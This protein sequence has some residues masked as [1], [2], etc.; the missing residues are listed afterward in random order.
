[1]DGMSGQASHGSK[2][3]VQPE[4]GVCKRRVHVQVGSD[5]CIALPEEWMRDLGQQDGDELAFAVAGTGVVITKM[6]HAGPSEE[7]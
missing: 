4:S 6:A 5:G 7:E 3:E 2:Q 1:V